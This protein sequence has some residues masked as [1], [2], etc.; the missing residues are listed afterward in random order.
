MSITIAVVIIIIILIIIIYISNKQVINKSTKKTYNSYFADPIDLYTETI[1]YEYDD[2]ASMAIEK[3]LI[4]EKKF[5]GI[6]NSS[7]KTLNSFIL[8]DLYRFNVVPNQKTK[9]NIKKNQLNSALFYNET[10]ER[11][12]DDPINI[13]RHP[14]KN[15]TPEFIINR[16]ENFYDNLEP[17]PVDEITRLRPNINRA[18]NIVRNTRKTDNPKHYYD[19]KPIAN[20]PQ[21]VHD[22]QVS[23]DVKY[24]FNKVVE[25]NRNE[26]YDPSFEDIR[27]DILKY[28]F[29]TKDHQYRA[30]RILN[31]FT[32]GN[33]NTNLG[34]T[35]DMILLNIYKRINSPENTESRDNLKAALFDSMADSMDKNQYGEYREVCLSG[36]CNRIIQSL[37][38][39]DNDEKISKPI[40]T[41]EILKNEVFAKSYKIIQD[42]L[43]RAD[44]IVA[45]MYNGKVVDSN[46]ET[47]TENAAKLEEFENKVKQ[48]IESTIKKDHTNIEPHILETLIED[49]QAG[50]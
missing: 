27:S 50:V 48:E 8:A 23:N 32:E 29:P 43:S 6:K 42:E 15:I 45:D 13:T 3:A 30:I 21:N 49:A 18:R 5:V 17:R 11:I 7:K 35:E 37:T 9:Q 24:I 28:K 19:Q 47:K 31:K 22:S 44:P 10:L 39:L 20:D 33:A 40:K 46:S 36:R 25:K 16:V 34:T 12:I 38:L 1:G 2:A 14:V 4:N 26:D 41:T